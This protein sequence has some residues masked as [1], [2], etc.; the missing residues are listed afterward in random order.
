MKGKVDVRVWE[1]TF[2]QCTVLLTISAEYDGGIRAAVSAVSLCVL[3]SL[4]KMNLF[5]HRGPHV[6]LPA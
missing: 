2:Q 1:S 6:H 5:V 4:C 3:I